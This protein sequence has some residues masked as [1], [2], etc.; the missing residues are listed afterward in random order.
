MSLALSNDTQVPT[1]MILSP[2]NGG[3]V[4][5]TV[6]VS[7]SAMDNLKVAK[8]ALTIDGKEVAVTTGSSLKYSWS[9]PR[10][11][12]KQSKASTITARANDPAGNLAT[13]SITVTRQ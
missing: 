7:V 2:S 3:T 11:K 4:S 13:T 6:T 8:V 10:P 9:V 1:V 12:G 5:G